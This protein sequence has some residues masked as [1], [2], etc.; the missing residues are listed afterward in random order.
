VDERE[1]PDDAETLLRQRHVA[2]VERLLPEYISRIEWPRARLREE[3]TAALRALLTTAVE[4]SPWHR[5][6]LG[7]ADIGSL[8]ESDIVDLPVMTKTDLM[9]NFDAIVTDGRLSRQ[10]CEDHLGRDPG[11]HLL[12]EFEVVASGGS[13]GQRGVYVYG[14]DA[15]AICY[16][17]AVRFQARDWSRDA[18]LAN[19][20]RV[21]AVVAASSPTHISAAFSKT[22]STGSNP[23]HLFPVSLPIDEIVGGLNTLQPTVLMGYSSFLPRLALE[24]QAGR[25]RISPKRV[26]AMSEPLLP[27]ARQG[28]QATWGAP[29]ANSYAMSEGVF[30]GFCGHGIHL[31]DDLCLFEAVDAQGRPVPAGHPSHRVLV[32]NLY[33][34][35]Q[36]LIR[37]EVTDEVAL[38]ERPCPCGSSM[39]LIDDP[40]GRL[41]DTFVYQPALSVHPHL[42]RSALG[43]QPS[44]IEYQVRQ[45]TRGAAISIVAATPVDLLPLE[46]KIADGLQALGLTDPHVTIE[47]VTAIRRQAS[48]KLARFVPLRN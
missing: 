48:G 2:A 8:S 20:P 40:Q 35:A 31:P 38:L 44:I 22:F 24:A 33:N 29:V 12:G 9:D 15:W 47:T 30:T 21:I 32:T 16:A 13:S 42:F 17:S 28:I 10:L 25:L 6:R 39:G 4:R 36:P 37:F 45:A 27:E 23:R 41:D 34:H 18:T 7:G 19:V 46:R 14:W 1:R 5:R 26:V 3:R 11:D 43:Q